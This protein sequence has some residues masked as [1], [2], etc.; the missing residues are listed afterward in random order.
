MER[1]QRIMLGNGLLVV[2]VAMFAGFMLMFDLI[3]GIEYWPG[4]MINFEVYGTDAGWVRAHSG[5]VTNGLLVMVV[6]LALP[7]L[8]L[9]TRMQ[10]WTC[11]GFVYIAWSFTVF[12]WLGNA[13]SNRAL[14]LGPSALGAPDTIGIIGFLP[15]VPSV[16]LVVVLL[17]VAARGVLAGGSSPP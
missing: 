5:G 13:S 1:Y 3:G 15:G 7:K 2:L 16:V 12:Y 6:A 17:W 4:K 11:W 8:G 9:S 10:A 14:T